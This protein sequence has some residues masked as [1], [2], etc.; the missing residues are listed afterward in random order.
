MKINF[1]IFRGNNLV[2]F[3]TTLPASAQAVNAATVVPAAAL[4]RIVTDNALHVASSAGAIR[5]INIG[6]PSA[7][8]PP[9]PTLATVPNSDNLI[10][11]LT[12][13][14]GGGLTLILFA[15]AG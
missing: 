2:L 4:T 1:I 5:I 15:C 6:R 10:I 9:P 7:F 3:Y 8:T 11:G 14:I 13:G 12:L